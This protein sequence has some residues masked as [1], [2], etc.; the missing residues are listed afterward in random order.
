MIIGFVQFMSHTIDSLRYSRASQLLG[1]SVTSLD[2]ESGILDAQF[3]SKPEFTNRAG[4]IQGGIVAAMLDDLMGYA[5]GITLPESHFAPTANM[6]VSFL[7][8]VP[9][10]I[11]H[12]RGQLLKQEQGVYQLFSKLYDENDNLLA[13]ATAKATLTILD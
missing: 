12:G 1:M 8:P 3:I 13:S 5:L 2:C 7:R 10:G 9:V 6:Q 4:N 11:L